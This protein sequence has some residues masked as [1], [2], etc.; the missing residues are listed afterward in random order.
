M[1]PETV[2]KFRLCLQPCALPVLLIHLALILQLQFAAKH[3]FLPLSFLNA[4]ILGTV[5]ASELFHN[6]TV[7][8]TSF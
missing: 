3:V 1:N 6:L 4:A 5:N 7:I 2:E 8:K